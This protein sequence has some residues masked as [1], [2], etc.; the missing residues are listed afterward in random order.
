[1]YWYSASLRALITSLRDHLVLT[2][3]HV[4]FTTCIYSYRYSDIP[5]WM[6]EI[7]WMLAFTWR[8]CC[9]T[10]QLYVQLTSN[11]ITVI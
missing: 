7:R 1:M 3:I 10:N 5:G 8:L 4:I 2:A 9:I 11:H 6:Q